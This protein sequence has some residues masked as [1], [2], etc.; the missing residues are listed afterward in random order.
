[1]EVVGQFYSRFLEEDN[2]TSYWTEEA[3]DTLIHMTCYLL[4]MAYRNAQGAE[5]YMRAVN[6]GVMSLDSAAVEEESI[7]VD[8]MKG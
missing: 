8:Q 4:E 1:M 3:L 5:I 7:N 6:E 2:D